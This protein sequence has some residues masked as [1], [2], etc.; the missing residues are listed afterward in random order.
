MAC[1]NSTQY[2]GAPFSLR[3]INHQVI[4][5]QI[6][7]TIFLYLN[8]LLLTS[9]F[10]KEI[11]RRSMRY[12]FFAFTL[13][14]DCLYLLVTNVLL[15]MSFFN[16]FMQI[17]LCIF[18]I[19]VSSVFNFVF[20]ITLTVMTLERYVAICMPMRHG[21][22]C[23]LRSTLHCILIIHTISSIPIS[24]IVSIYFASVPLSIYMEDALCSIEML[25]IHRWQSYL[26]LAANQ[27]YFIIMFVII[28]V[29]YIQ[30]TKAARK[31]SGE[32]KKSTGKGLRTINH[33][34]IVVQILITIFLYLNCL[35]LTSFFKKEI[36]RRSMRYIFFVF[37]LMSDCLYLL[38][39][40]V[41]LI[42]S[43]FNT[44]MQI[45]LCIFLII[46][47]SVFNFVFPL[48]LTAMTLERYVAICM[49]M[50]HGALC[51][52]RS[53]LHCILII[54]TISSIPISIIVSIYFASVPLSIYM[55]DGLCSI[56]MLMIHRWQSYLLSAV[57]QLYFIIMFVIIVF[58]YI[59]IT[60]AARKASGETKTSTGKGLRTV[61]LHG[62]QLI[63]CLTQLWC[64]FVEA[65]VLQ[66]DFLLYI[67]C[68]APAVLI[69]DIGLGKRPD[70]APR[71]FS[72]Q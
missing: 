65:A 67:N 7:I 49:P 47:L 15:L 26:F 69:T 38:V 5:V 30:I 63:L 27:L 60:K 72:R 56:E 21:A 59:E 18:L 1:N 32:T 37:T 55:E 16:I 52:P 36:F 8:C 61:L 23:T 45:W 46:V 10:K 17:W 71:S 28:V 64:P 14:S 57:N 54:H 9:F 68:L 51:T 41:L 70:D 25:M 42:L 58:C 66:I 44:F 43:F 22:L 35:L 39:T 12:I 62:F 31:A 19:I 11:F 53:A 13:M 48:T 33:K 50:R 2:D 20:P 29:C 40:N 34:V 4:V 3:K 6:L 24:I